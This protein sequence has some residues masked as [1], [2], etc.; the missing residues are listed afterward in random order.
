MT[1]LIVLH[2]YK[3]HFT[4]NAGILYIIVNFGIYAFG[5]TR[6]Y[7]G[8]NNY[9]IHIVLLCFMPFIVS[10]ELKYKLF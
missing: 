6:D 8:L 10:L 2:C 4:F 5:K 3:R 7:F 9:M 1:E